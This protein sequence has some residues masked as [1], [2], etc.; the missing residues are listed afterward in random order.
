MTGA[1]LNLVD[2]SATKKALRSTTEMGDAVMFA[3]S[4]PLLLLDAALKVQRANAAFYDT[5][6][7]APQSMEGRVIFEVGSGEWDIPQLRDML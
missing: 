4:D 3:V 1:V 7:V 6:R 2:V 5:F